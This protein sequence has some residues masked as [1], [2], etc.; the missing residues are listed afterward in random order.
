MRIQA[1][2]QAILTLQFLVTMVSGAM[3]AVIGVSVGFAQA[4]PEIA[5]MESP[6][7]LTHAMNQ[8]ILAITLLTVPYVHLTEILAQTRFAQLELVAPRPII[9]T[10][11]IMAPGAMEPIPV[12]GGLA[13]SMLEEIVRMPFPAPQIPAMKAPIPVI[14]LPTTRPVPM[15]FI[16]MVPKCVMFPWVAR[17]ELRWPAVTVNGAMGRKL[18][19]SQRI[20]ARPAPLPIARTP[21][22]APLIPA[23]RRRIPAPIRPITPPAKTVSIATAL[24]FVMRLLAVKRAPQ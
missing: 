18:A 16:A 17:L 1:I 4:Q 19:T 21:F 12:A 3:V 23:M 8:R 9:A 5:R 2:A 13:V 22:P 7:R 20:R 10:L 14:T 11:V 6:A 24:R 15:A